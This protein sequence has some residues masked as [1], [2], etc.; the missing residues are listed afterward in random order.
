[1]EY[2]SIIISF[3]VGGGLTTILNLRLSKKAMETANKSQKVD[4]ADKAVKFMEGQNDNLM[5]RVIRLES[6]ILKLGTFR[7]ERQECPTRIP[8]QTL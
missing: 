2:L 6:E 8:P 1:M 7:C 5:E 3:I 4:F